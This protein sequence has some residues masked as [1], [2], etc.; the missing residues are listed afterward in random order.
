MRTNQPS[1][2][3]LRVRQESVREV[4]KKKLGLTTDN[5][6]AQAIGMHPSTVSQI[7]QGRTEPSEKFIVA[8]LDTLG[9]KFEDLFYI[10]VVAAA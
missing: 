9:S 4:A 5:A 1:I 2:R 10:E 7:F 8:T 3:R 6:L